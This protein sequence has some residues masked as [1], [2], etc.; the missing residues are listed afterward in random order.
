M[1]INKLWSIGDIDKAIYPASRKTKSLSPFI[2][3]AN[4]ADQGTIKSIGVGRLGMYASGP[5]SQPSDDA[6]SEF[7]RSA[8]EKVYIFQQDLYS[9]LKTELTA[10]FTMDAITSAAVRGVHVTIVQSNKGDFGGYGAVEPKATYRGVLD[11]AVEAF[12]NTGNSRDA[13]RKLACSAITYA[14]FRFSAALSGWPQ[15]GAKP[16]GT[17]TK[18][19]IVDD[20][21]FYIGSHNLYPANLQEYGNIVFDSTATAQLN[22]AY[23]NKLWK[24]SEPS[25]LPCPY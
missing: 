20:A 9:Q 12:Q 14:P 7:I 24:E 13:S 15:A 6:L 17:H 16:L 18:L 2:S 22:E 1:N 19:V 25:V 10:T 11:R 23:W 21:A 8:K 3:Q 5:T 4:S